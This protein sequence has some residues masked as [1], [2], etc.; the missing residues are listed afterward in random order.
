MSL[1]SFSSLK[2]RLKRFTIELHISP[3]CASH[4]V[5]A[6]G[7]VKP[8][9]GG[10][11]EHAIYNQFFVNLVAAPFLRTPQY[12]HQF[13]KETQHLRFALFFYKYKYKT[14]KLSYL[15]FLFTLI[16]LIL[17]LKH[18]MIELHISPACASH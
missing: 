18:F 16:V 2:K 11:P 4:S 9:R 10:V 14:I 8:L 1:Y 3:A 12:N 5:L 13:P 17:R 6:S 15:L 7:E